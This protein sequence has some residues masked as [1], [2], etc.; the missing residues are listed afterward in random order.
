M[1]SQSIRRAGHHFTMLLSGHAAVVKQL[2]EAGV[3]TKAV[4]ESGVTPLHKAAYG[5]HEAVVKQLLEDGADVKAV[6]DGGVTPLH[7]AAEGG[8]G[9]EERQLGEEG[10][11]AREGDEDG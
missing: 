11:D 10:G 7:D 3:D 1:R 5:G 4:N 2:L 6:S 9:A 8:H